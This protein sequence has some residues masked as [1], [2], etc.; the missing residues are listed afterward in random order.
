MYVC[1]CVTHPLIHPLTHSLTHTLTHTY[2]LTQDHVAAAHFAVACV[3]QLLE[4][5]LA[6]QYIATVASSVEKSKLQKAYPHINLTQPLI[7]RLYVKLRK[8]G[9][10]GQLVPLT[11]QAMQV[12]VRVKVKVRVRVRVRVRVYG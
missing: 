12:R 9:G 4:A 8:D 11:K 2:S 3:Q 5:S 10:R 7:R 6:Q 1:V